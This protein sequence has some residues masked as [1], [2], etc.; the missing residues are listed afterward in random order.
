MQ[1]AESA[2][3]VPL[4]NLHFGPET[5][6]GASVTVLT[7]WILVTTGVDKELTQ[8]RRPTIATIPPPNCR[9]SPIIFIG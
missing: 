9:A 1:K 3:T 6:G 5:A 8:R 4:Q 7:S 2:P